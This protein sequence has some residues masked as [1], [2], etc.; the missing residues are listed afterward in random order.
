MSHP[1]LSQA[2]SEPQDASQAPSDT[3]SHWADD[4]HLGLRLQL[5]DWRLQHCQEETWNAGH[6][7]D[8][9]WATIVDALILWH[10]GRGMSEQAAMRRAHLQ[11]YTAWLKSECQPGDRYTHKRIAKKLGV[12]VKTVEGYLAELKDVF[13]HSPCRRGAS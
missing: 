6:A 8:L 10:A 11:A 1:A 4:L 13:S 12:S 7:E 2:L 3:G 9:S 5:F